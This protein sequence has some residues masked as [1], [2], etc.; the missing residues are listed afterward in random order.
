MS[1]LDANLAATLANQRRLIWRHMTLS[2]ITKALEYGGSMINYLCL[3]LAVFGGAWG[4]EGGSAGA[5]AGRISVA[6]FYLLMLIYSFTQVRQIVVDRDLRSRSKVES[7]HVPWITR[8]CLIAAG[9]CVLTGPTNADAPSGMP[10]Y[11]KRGSLV[12]GSPY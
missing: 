10:L 3:G 12:C 6:S 11:C 2:L 4:D 7:C 1:H 8:S 9:V 5:R